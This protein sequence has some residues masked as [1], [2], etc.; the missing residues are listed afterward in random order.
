MISSSAAP[1]PTGYVP[2]T[3]AVDRR[4][5]SA[6]TQLRSSTDRLLASLLVVQWIA[7]IG[8]SI[9]VSPQAWEGRETATHIHA[10]TAILLG[11]V[12]CLYPAWLGWNRPGQTMTRHMM[13]IGQMLVSALLIDLTAG[14]IETHFHVFASLALLALYRDVRVLVTATVVVYVDHLVRGIFWPESIYGVLTP[15]VWRSVEHAGWIFFEVTFLTVAVKAGLKEMRELVAR[16]IGLEK[17]NHEK[18]REVED[19]TQELASSE[20]QFRSLFRDSPIGLY[21][22]SPGGEFLMANPALLTILGFASLDDLRAAKTATGEPVIDSGR[23]QFFTQLAASSEVL[24]RDAIWRRKDGSPLQIRESGRAFRDASKRIAHVDGAIEDITEHRQLEERFRQAQKVQAIGQLAG[25]IAHDF[26]NILTV[27]SGYSQLL[28]SKPEFSPEVRNN[29]SHINDAGNRA[30]DLTRQLLAFSRKQRLQPR[31]IYLNAIAAEMDPMLRRLV[32]ENIR[33]RTIAVSG[34][35]PVKADPSQIEQVVMNLVVNARDAMPGGGQL[36][37]E[38]ANVTLGEDYALGHH[39]VL[40]GNYVMLAVSDSGVGM[41]PEVQARLFEPFF[42]TKA[43]GYG[44]GLGLATCH[45]IVKQSGGHIAAYS[46]VGHGTTFKVYLPSVEAPPV[47]TAVKPAPRKHYGAGERILL[48]EDDR[49]VRDF[50]QGVL[51]ALGYSVISAANGLEAFDYF[52]EHPE[53][54]LLVTDV[55]MPSMGGC[56][57]VENIRKSAPNVPVL[58]TSGYTFDAL[59]ETAELGANSD[60][61]AKPYSPDELSQKVHET[62]RTRGR[63]SFSASSLVEP[64]EWLRG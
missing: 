40:P 35:A 8:V 17:F 39:D 27:I 48:V 21:R 13:A 38:T 43:P 59:G 52:K 24:H 12:V 54:D 5:T 44:T 60:F 32:G 62:L 20:E 30:T 23:P 49:T 15:T 22:V 64:S 28:M 14:R 18:V 57:L 6:L 34:L 55:I 2:D 25:G 19:R 61:L 33:I 56:K 53:I 36:T 11:G 1:F 26:N 51:Q 10:W 7:M 41:S 16:Q 4:F 47:E 31:V 29:L 50:G 46:E 45:G 63:G 58:F 9:V 3:A 42:T 37:I